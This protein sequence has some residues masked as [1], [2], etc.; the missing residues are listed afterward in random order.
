MTSRRG[1]NNGSFAF[2]R[3]LTVKYCQ[4][5]ACPMCARLELNQTRTA[6]KGTTAVVQNKEGELV[7]RPTEPFTAETI[8]TRL[9]E[10]N[11]GS[12]KM[13]LFLVKLIRLLMRH[14]VS[15]SNVTSTPRQLLD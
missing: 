8:L 7:Q 3:V 6:E 9:N 10:K 2:A 14:S 12:T 5:R 1:K 15:M 13:F 11:P 4:T